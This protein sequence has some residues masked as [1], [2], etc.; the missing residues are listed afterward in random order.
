MIKAAV[1]D[2]DHT[3]FDRYETL[4]LVAPRFREKYAVAEGITD[5]FIAQEIIWAD[6]NYVHHGWQE[7]HAHLIKKGIFEVAP[8][9]DDYVEFLLSCF[10]KTA[11][12]F[13]FSIPTLKK[14][15]DM[16]IKTGLITN[17]RHEIQSSKLKL[18]GLEDS[19]D[20]IVISG[21]TGTKK[22]DPVIYKIAAD[23][24]GVELG[25]MM[26]IGDHPK[27]DVDGSR[28]AGCVPCWVKTTG[29]WIFPEIE[30][31]ELQVETVAEIPAIIEKLNKG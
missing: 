10:A 3:L 17:G 1:F 24:L 6:K 13:D 31:P 7:I 22:P 11:V 23:R 21:D 26:Y 28:K 12:P 8:E 15:R 9:Y 19:F 25:D 2:L 20:A 29:T 14:L 30:K 27:L 18:L 5:E 16:G 4:K